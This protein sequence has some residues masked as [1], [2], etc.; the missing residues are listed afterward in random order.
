MPQYWTEDRYSTSS[1]YLS[2]ILCYMK[3]SWITSQHPPWFM[4]GETV[5]LA[6][7]TFT[8]RSSARLAC[9]IQIVPLTVFA[10]IMRLTYCV[11]HEPFRLNRSVDSSTGD[12]HIRCV[13]TRTTLWIRTTCAPLSQIVRN[14]KTRIRTSNLNSNGYALPGILLL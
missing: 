12:T 9:Q 1:L 10:L 6:K 13:L 4:I 8:W 3:L 14:Y 2:L 11:T 7:W 5:L